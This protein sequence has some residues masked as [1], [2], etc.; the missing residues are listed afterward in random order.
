V[1]LVAAVLLA[2]LVLHQ[3]W[4]WLVVLLGGGVE[5][6]EATFWWHWSHRRRAAA[7]VE[8]LV[9]RVVEVDEDGWARVAGE[10]WHVRGAGPGERGRVLAVDGLT[11]VVER[12]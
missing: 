12:D 8:A 5:L 4:D 7:G 11:L 3:P 1:A 2:L 10:R 6:G 9:G